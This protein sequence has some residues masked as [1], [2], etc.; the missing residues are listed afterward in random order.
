MEKLTDQIQLIN[1][2]GIGPITF[3]RLIE[4]FGTA[5]EALKNL[6]DKYNIF[7]RANAELEVKLAKQKNIH[8]ISYKDPLYPQGLLELDDAPPI[9]YAK[10]N[11]ELLTHPVA[12]S[13][14]GARNASINGRKIISKIAYDLT[15]NDV[16]VISGM[17]RGIDTSAHKGAMHAKELC[18]PTIAVLGT[19][20]D[21]VYPKE[22]TAIYQQISEQGLIISEFPIGTEPQA[23][24]FPRRNR[25]VAGMSI[26]T[27]VGEASINSG[28]LITARLALEQGKDI[29]AIPGAP[30]DTRSSGPNKLIKDGAILVEN[31]DDIINIISITNNHK[32]K[33]LKSYKQENLFANSLDNCEKNVN[34]RQIIEPKDRKD[35][36]DVLSIIDYITVDGVCV[37]DLVRTMD[38]DAA[39]VSIK[40]F[41]L[42]MSGKIERKVGN[43]VALV[44]KK[45]SK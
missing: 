33:H 6:P 26:A 35:T 10:G 28:S 9:L 5:A 39:A 16:L 45:S 1:T 4:K 40:L 37:D 12:V 27:L 43:K 31:S 15:N 13:I 44:S 20:V 21:I 11:I 36:S 7:S 2:D 17:A 19:G 3:Y 25:I 42:E 32:I 23:Q 8:I 14:V 41:E 22:N 18:G 30:N 29:F 34:S 38:S 24:N